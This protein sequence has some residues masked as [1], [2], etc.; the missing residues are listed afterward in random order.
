M[1]KLRSFIYHCFWNDIDLWIQKILSD[2]FWVPVALVFSPT[3]RYQLVIDKIILV[4]C[5]SAV[6]F[7]TFT[8]LLLT[9]F[10]TMHDT[11]LSADYIPCLWIFHVS[12]EKIN[13]QVRIR[14]S[15]YEMELILDGMRT[16]ATRV[17]DKVDSQSKTSLNITQEYFIFIYS[18]IFF[19]FSFC[20]LAMVYLVWTFLSIL[21]FWNCVLRNHY[22]VIHDNDAAQ[23]FS[24]LTCPPMWKLMIPFYKLQGV[25]TIAWEMEWLELYTKDSTFI[26]R[27]PSR[28]QVSKLIYMP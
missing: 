17:W 26:D 2:K 25:S 14:I 24:P 18:T 3:V 19:H 4:E 6:T 5:K 28:G 27:E 12:S 15:R 23:L 13:S 8:F 1:K 20:L 16:W 7:V 21:E 10:L 9:W 22:F 11:L